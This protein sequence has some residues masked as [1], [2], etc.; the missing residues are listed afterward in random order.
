MARR[1][2][3]TTGANSGIGL[4][5]ALE[6]ARRG[7]RSVGSVRSAAK[8]RQVEAAAAAAGVRVETVIFDVTDAAA[9]RRIINRL[10]P[11]ALVNNAGFPATGAVEDVDD[12]EARMVLETMVLAPMRLARLALPH[13]RRRGEGRIINISSIYGLTTTPLS[14]W[15]QGAKHALEGLSDALRM[16]VAST[17]VKVILVEP[18]GFKTGIWEESSGALERRP[19]SRYRSAYSRA[20][21]G[22]GASQVL[23]GEP[24]TVAKVIA[25]AVESSRP[26]TRYLVGYDAMMLAAMDRLTPTVIKDRVSRLTL[27][28]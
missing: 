12:D 11:Y 20:L 27:G 3:L 18:G 26:R 16:E 21:K 2:V 23:M 1:T 17:G 4:V 15:Y 14:G 9:G 7:F 22:F 24:E 19:K 13:M 28:L 25:G 5:T 6:L 10:R 8:A